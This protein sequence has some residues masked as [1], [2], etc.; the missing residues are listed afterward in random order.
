M[1]KQIKCIL[2][3]VK[4]QILITSMV[5][6]QKKETSPAQEFASKDERNKWVIE[7]LLPRMEKNQWLYFNIPRQ[8]G[9]LLYELVLKTKRKSGLELGSANG[10]SAIWIGMAIDSNNGKLKTVEM[11]VAKAKKC[12]NNVQKSG[13]LETVTCIQGEALKVSSQLKDTFDFL[14]IDTG[15]TN[16]LPFFK[17]LEDKLTDDAI[18]TLHNLGFASSYKELF[19]FVIKKD[20]IVTKI[21]PSS[22]RGE[23]LFILSKKSNFDLN[24]Y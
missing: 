14:F 21:K 20:W 8:D 13:L 22:G 18:I 23:G 16:P 3:I 11:N 4:L 7:T 6:G 17:A 5:F 19:E 10:Y 2:I 9:K 24:N 15:M 12:K 1:N